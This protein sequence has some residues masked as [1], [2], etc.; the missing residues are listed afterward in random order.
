M[1][2]HNK[3]KEYDEAD[4]LSEKAYNSVLARCVRHSK[5]RL[6]IMTNPTD[7]DHWI[8]RRVFGDEPFR[9]PL[10]LWYPLGRDNLEEEKTDE[11]HRLSDQR[12]PAIQP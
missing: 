9:K 3:V 6:Q 1:T 11:S 7:E 4:S 2:D 12:P 5:P 10:V 8:Y